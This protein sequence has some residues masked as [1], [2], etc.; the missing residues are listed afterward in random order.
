MPVLPCGHAVV[1]S[2]RYKRMHTLAAALEVAAGA[3]QRADSELLSAQEAT[4]EAEMRVAIAQAQ[5]AVA[6]QYERLVDGFCS[7]WPDARA[8]VEADGLQ[9]PGAHVPSDPLQVCAAAAR[10]GP[11]GAPEAVRAAK[12]QSAA[13]HAAEFG[14]KGAARRAMLIA[15][16][17]ATAALASVAAAWQLGV[18]PI[19]VLQEEWEADSGDSGSNGGAP[20]PARIHNTAISVYDPV[21]G[22]PLNFTEPS[23]YDKAGVAKPVADPIP[24][25]KVAFTRVELRHK[26]QLLFHRLDT[27][28]AGRLPAATLAQ[29]LLGPAGGDPGRVRAVALALASGADGAALVAAEQFVR[30]A[31]VLLLAS[32]GEEVRAQPQMR[33]Q[34]QTRSDERGASDRV[35]QRS[36]GE[37]A[38]TKHGAIFTPAFTPK[39]TVQ[40]SERT[41]NLLLFT[42]LRC[43]GG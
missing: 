16:H 12:L 23:R 37:T 22:Q 42:P 40:R 1:L 10:A 26:L 20:T 24:D 7:P 8:K 25:A 19:E 34:A 5:P 21:S 41:P 18:R 35:G 36:K 30:N 3:I 32:A 6:V 39:C 9:A 28:K 38:H 31:A 14:E 13:M 17:R 27:G 2:C 33:M 11:P 29:R 4:I 15:Q 43:E